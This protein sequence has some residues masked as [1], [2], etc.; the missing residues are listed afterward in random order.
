MLPISKE[1]INSSLLLLN[2]DI[3]VKDIELDDSAFC[4]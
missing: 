4:L 1:C 3:L 2:P